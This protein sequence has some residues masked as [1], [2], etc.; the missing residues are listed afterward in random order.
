MSESF[1]A[2]MREAKLAK[3]AAR[4]RGEGSGSFR[5]TVRVRTAE[6]LYGDLDGLELD[7]AALV[8]ATFQDPIQAFGADL[9]AAVLDLND[10]T[11]AEIPF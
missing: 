2:R 3:L 8:R 5:G 11:A 6:S 4:N 9:A 7:I 10:D 1:A